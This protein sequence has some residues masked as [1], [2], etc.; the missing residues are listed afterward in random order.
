MTYIYWS[1]LTAV[2]LTHQM[3]CS[4]VSRSRKK[5]F[6]KTRFLGSQERR[7]QKAHR[8]SVAILVDC[9]FAL[10]EERFLIQNYIQAIA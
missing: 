1:N 8:F 2:N 4:S 10:T 3:K 7:R 6:G 5:T 9:V